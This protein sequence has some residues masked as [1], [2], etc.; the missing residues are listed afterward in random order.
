VSE[1]VPLALASNPHNHAY[2]ATKRDRTGH[3]ISEIVNNSSDAG[4]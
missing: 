4:T 3:M 1:R 2:L